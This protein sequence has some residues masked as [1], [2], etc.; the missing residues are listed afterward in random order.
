MI[1]SMADQARFFVWTL[2]LG[3]AA[4]ITYDAFRII[5]KVVKHPDILTHLEDLL[6]WLFITIAVF[7]FV[8][9]HNSGEVRIYAIIGLFSGMCLYFVS[10]SS[11]VIKVSVLIIDIAKKIIF[12]ATNII[13]YP[14][15]LLYKLL[16]YPGRVIKKWSI[17]QYEHSKKIIRN[18]NRLAKIKIIKMQ[19]EIYIIRKKI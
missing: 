17:K 18:T 2:L 19:R 14:L 11:L 15:K 8:L 12:T 9:H 1:L 6:Y 7:Y 3:A 4:G 13:L 10:L 16:S 5:R